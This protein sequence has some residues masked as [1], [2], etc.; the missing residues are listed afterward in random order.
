MNWTNTPVSEIP[1]GTREE[2]G[3]IRDNIRY[4]IAKD[5]HAPPNVA[6]S[7]VYEADELIRALRG[8]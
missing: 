7:A 1:Y 8:M 4:E 2:R 5:T 3:E 6:N